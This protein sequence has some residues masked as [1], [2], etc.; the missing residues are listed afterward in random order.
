M[1]LEQFVV[2]WLKKKRQLKSLLHL[3][4]Y[5]LKVKPQSVL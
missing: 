4:A 2:C 1:I 3:I 5:H